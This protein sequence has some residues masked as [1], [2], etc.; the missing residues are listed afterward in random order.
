MFLY[1]KVRGAMLIRAACSAASEL[2]RN[3]VIFTH[4]ESE[5][6]S[7]SLSCQL[8]GGI[9]HW[10]PLTE[11]FFTGYSIFSLRYTVNGRSRNWCKY[12]RDSVECNK[13]NIVPFARKYCPVR[14]F[15][16][17]PSMLSSWLVLPNFLVLFPWLPQGSRVRCICGLEVRHWEDTASGLDSARGLAQVGSCHSTA[18][19]NSSFH[20][21][22][23]QAPWVVWESSASFFC[24]MGS[25]REEILVTVFLI[26]IC[27]S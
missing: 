4:W 11:L 27:I 16:I 7:L 2:H 24:W 10:S 13:D 5:W 14:H 17:F 20:P 1:C 18:V 26:S 15:L 19:G 23:S 22:F 6:A 21:A 9:T 3:A 8:L 12:N 25:G